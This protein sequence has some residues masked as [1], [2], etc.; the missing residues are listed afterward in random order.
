LAGGVGGGAG[1]VEVGLGA[2]RVPDG[3][4][5]GGELRTAE[6]AA[7]D[8]REGSIRRAVRKARRKVV[9]ARV[10]LRTAFITVS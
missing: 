2:E 1:E 8:G 10:V 7:D 3:G 5:G 9:W 4:E 6:P